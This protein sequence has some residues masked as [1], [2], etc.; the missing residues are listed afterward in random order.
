MTVNSRVIQ[1]LLGY[2]KDAVDVPLKNG[3]RMQV[4]PTMQDLPKARKYQSGAFIA[5]DGLL[6]VWDDDPQNLLERAG[7]I[8]AEVMELVWRMN[9]NDEEADGIANEKSAAALDVEDGAFSPL[10]RPTNLMNTTLVAFTLIIVIVLLG[11]AARSLAVEIT[12]DHNWIRL[13]FLA[14]VPIQIFFTLVSEHNRLHN[15]C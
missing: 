13:A 7:A 9:T 15:I 8:E 11:L 2:S 1:T 6:V 14:L 5:S 12:V 10:A 3:L 4:L